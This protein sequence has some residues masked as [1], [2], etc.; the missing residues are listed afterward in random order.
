M[1]GP[2][3]WPASICL[4]IDTRECVKLRK[5]REARA[6]LAHPVL[7][8]RIVDCCRAVLMVEERT[9][10]QIF[11]TPDD[12]KL[13]SSMTL[14][15]QVSEPGSAFHIVLDRYF[16]GVPDPRTL[17]LLVGKYGD[18]VVG[19]PGLRV[20]RQVVASACSGFC[21]AGSRSTSAPSAHQRTEAVSSDSAN[22][23][24]RS[25][26]MADRSGSSFLRKRKLRSPGGERNVGLPPARE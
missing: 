26:D 4:R 23:S 25:Q 13:R 18:S 15:A 6:Y 9:A 14:F 12:L 24:E 2:C 7:G 21:D 19:L 22:L 20:R 17:E 3:A 1:V 10:R 16:D 5:A 8:K 11:G